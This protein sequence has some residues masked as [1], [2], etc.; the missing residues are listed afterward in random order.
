VR[1]GDPRVDTQAALALLGPEWGFESLIDITD[2]Q[3][4]D[5]LDP[6]ALPDPLARRGRP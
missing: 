6:R 4:R 2:E 1:S 5:D 3:A